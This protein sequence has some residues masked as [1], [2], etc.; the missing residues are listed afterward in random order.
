MNRA[1]SEAEEL[2]NVVLPFAE[3]L[4]ARHGEFFPFGAAM[5]HLGGIS[6]QAA[7]S[8]T[9]QPPSSELIDLLRSAFR[10]AGRSGECRATAL[11]YD[12]RTQLPGSE[13]K[14]DAVAVELDHIDSYS[15]VTY[16]PYVLTN[17]AVEFGSA[18]ARAGENNVFD[19]RHGHSDA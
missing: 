18:F 3:E 14:S 4:L 10:S 11:A 19:S 13:T 7:Y 2:L 8:G 6:H 17:G 5:N 12:V 15:V 9:E 1:K 16:F